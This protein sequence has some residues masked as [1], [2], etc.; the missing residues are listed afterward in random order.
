MEILRYSRNMYGQE[1][2]QGVSWELLWVFF[3]VATAF[4][5]LHGIYS[6]ICSRKKRK[7]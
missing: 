3:G 5:V 4:I 2:L 6:L 7:Q 1:V